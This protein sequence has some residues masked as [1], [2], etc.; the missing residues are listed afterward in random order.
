M[1]KMVYRVT[2]KGPNSMEVE[3]APSVV[4]IGHSWTAAS[5][6]HHIRTKTLRCVAG[7]T[8]QI[9]RR[10]ADSPKRPW[11]QFRA[12]VMGDNGIVRRTDV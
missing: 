2:G 4:E 12:Y 10:R 9:L 3:V 8:H 11:V 5:A 7:Y 1:A 6:I